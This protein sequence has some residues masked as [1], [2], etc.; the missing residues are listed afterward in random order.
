MFRNRNV[1]QEQGALDALRADS[2]I[3]LP[4]PQLPKLVISASDIL[5]CDSRDQVESKS[6]QDCCLR[7]YLHRQYS[8]AESTDHT[9]L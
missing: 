5:I 8:W 2:D 3:E 1:L 7:S 9:A 6:K 4:L